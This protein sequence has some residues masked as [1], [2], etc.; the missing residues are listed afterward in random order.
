MKLSTIAKLALYSYDHSTDDIIKLGCTN[1][2]LIEKDSERVFV[3]RYH[4]SLIIAFKGTENRQDIIEDLKV[5]SKYSEDK[6][7]GKVHSGFNQ[8]YEQV[9]DQIDVFIDDIRENYDIN[10]IITIGHSKGGAMADLAGKEYAFRYALPVK[11]YTF[12]AARVFKQGYQKPPANQIHFRYVNGK[13][14]VPRLP[15]KYMGYKHSAKEI[16]LKGG[17]YSFLWF[18]NWRDHSMKKYLKKLKIF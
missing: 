1:V 9:E 12:G 2:N 7:I 14:P 11:T 15:R 5:K 6:R 18:G 10:T 16:H 17:W 4:K 3:C 13:D 8:A